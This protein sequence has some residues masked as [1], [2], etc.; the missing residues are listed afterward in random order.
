M[1]LMVLKCPECVASLSIE[2]GREEI[3]C[4]YC[5]AKII[6]TNENEYI[7]RHIN[8]AEIKRAETERLV[9]LKEIEI[10]EKEIENSR[11]G[12]KV[13]YIIAIICVILGGI[14]VNIDGYIGALA[15]IGGI[16]L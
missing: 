10:E 6:I 9:K 15:I 8:D 16:E 13:A 11:K 7:Y 14:M 5:G 1:N 12:T 3:F 2:D 4:S